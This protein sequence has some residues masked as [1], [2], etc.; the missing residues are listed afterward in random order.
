[1][2]AIRDLPPRARRVLSGAGCPEVHR[3]VV[4]GQLTCNGRRCRSTGDGEVVGL[5]GRSVLG[6]YFDPDS[7]AP[8]VKFNCPVGVHPCIEILAPLFDADRRPPVILSR[9][10]G[11]FRHV[12]A[13]LD[14][15]PCGVGVKGWMPVGRA[16]ERQAAQCGVRGERICLG[17]STCS[18][19]EQSG[20][21]YRGGNGEGRDSE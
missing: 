13:D 6:G 3:R 20:D 17:G 11:N 15:V 21:Y 14:G 16:A 18:A 5:R 1:M 10:D 19:E 8:S 4:R 2:T 9:S 7:V 12:V